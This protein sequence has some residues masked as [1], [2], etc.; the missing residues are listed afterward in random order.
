MLFPRQPAPELVLDPVDQRINHGIPIR[1]RVELPRELQVQVEV[2]GPPLSHHLVPVAL[3]VKGQ[4]AVGA[5]PEG[6]VGGG[7]KGAEVGAAP[8]GEGGGPGACGQSVVAASKGRQH[9]RTASQEAVEQHGMCSR[10][11]MHHPN[12]A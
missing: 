7:G 4:L 5:A 3:G 12:A 1:P 10:E 8:G 11:E 6:G 2:A 9:S